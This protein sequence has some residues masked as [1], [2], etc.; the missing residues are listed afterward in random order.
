MFFVVLFSHFGYE[1]L[2]QCQTIL[3]GAVTRELIA[4]KDAA[5]FILNG[6]TCYL[7]NDNNDA[8]RS[9]RISPAS[10]E[11][12]GTWLLFDTLN[13]ATPI[14]EVN[15]KDGIKNG[16]S[17]RRYPNGMLW[18]KDEY[19]NGNLN[20][21]CIKYHDNGTIASKGEYLNGKKTDT[22][23]YFY[24]NG[25]IQFSDNYNSS[26]ELHGSSYSLNDNG[27]LL[28]SVQYINGKPTG[29]GLIFD[30]GIV[31]GQSFYED[32][33]LVRELDS[34][35][36]DEKRKKR[37]SVA[38]NRN[39]PLYQRE[40]LY[41]NGLITTRIFF[42]NGNIRSEESMVYMGQKDCI[43][44]YRNAGVHSYWNEKGRL[45]KCIAHENGNAID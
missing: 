9:Y 1:V 21:A 41:Y 15:Y 16:V 37:K 20:G 39:T 27:E 26:G 24:Q 10:A 17:I 13:S 34:I 45:V 32:G 19:R 5:S 8:Q 35:A 25:G 28:W 43:D 14:L 4:E 42:P 12:D 29:V 36:I 2:A 33:K 18:E 23:Q 44:V 31:V 7:F 30:N 40:I 3:D 38:S 11:I 6:K 22:H